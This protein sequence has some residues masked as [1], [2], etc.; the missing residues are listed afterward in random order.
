M[1]IVTQKEFRELYKEP[2]LEKTEEMRRTLA[3]LPVKGTGKKRIVRKSRLALVLGLMLAFSGIAAVAN[4]GSMR[5]FNWDGKEVVMDQKYDPDQYP[6]E[7]EELDQQMMDL[8][9]AAPNNLYAT[10]DWLEGKG[11]NKRDIIEETDSKERLLEVLDAAGYPYPAELR[12]SEEF[13]SATIY[14]GCAVDGEYE[15][16]D[17]TVEGQFEVET[18]RVAPDKLVPIAY[19]VSF[20]AGSKYSYSTEHLF[21]YGGYYSSLST[22]ESSTFGF[23]TETGPQVESIDIPGMEKTLYTTFKD[24]TSSLYMIRPLEKPI[25]VRSAPL[26]FIEDF[27]GKLTETMEFRYEQITAMDMTLENAGELFSETK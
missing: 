21:S 20:R 14:Y 4:Y 12:D 15:L 10:V 26:A 24:K 18:Y 17:K 1:K 7:A 16:V 25:T 19:G 11:G 8:L 3:Y 9:Y 6:E 13:E 5:W 27:P 2:G 23:G 22:D